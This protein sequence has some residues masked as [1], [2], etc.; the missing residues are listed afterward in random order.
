MKE[1]LFSHL[2]IDMTNTHVPNG[3]AADLQAECAQYDESIEKSGGID[4][5]LLGIGRNGHIG[6]N[7]PGDS[8]ICGCHI[9][10]LTQST[11]D[12]NRRFFQS[13]SNVPR[14]AISLGIGN[15]MRARK[16]LLLATGADKAE[17]IHCAI[18]GDINPR[19]PATILQN[20]PNAIFLL[21]REAAKLL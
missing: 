3:N 6:F 9:V 11:I 8:F 12:A 20:H 4:I 10:N 14:Q 5:Q 2:N 7:E 17:A 16:V 13:E 1:Q 21:D 18:H 15:I 19:M